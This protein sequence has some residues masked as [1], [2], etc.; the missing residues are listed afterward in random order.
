M[1]RPI[2]QGLDYFPVDVGF[3]HNKKIK[4]LRRAKG[5][6]GV[7]TYFNLMCRI[8][9][10]GYYYRF[11]DID[12]LSMDI[13]EEIACE[14]LRATAS[15]VTETINYLVGRGILD[16]ELFKRG[17]ISGQAMQEQYVLATKAAKRK[18]NMDVHLLVDVDLVVQKNSVSA[19]ESEVS[20]EETKVN[21]ENGTQSKVNKI[22]NNNSLSLSACTRVEPTIVDAARY[23]EQYGLKKTDALKEAEKFIEFNAS[24]SWDCLKKGTWEQTADS[25]L[26]RKE[27]REEAV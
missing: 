16:E 1:A 12:E 11:D 4:N 20:S 7:M 24:R 5:T 3:F 9:E 13:A 18:V 27:E 26:A 23:F 19:E 14:Q 25:W 10:N 2:K 6:I 22:N 15:R 21:A 17:I 8:Y